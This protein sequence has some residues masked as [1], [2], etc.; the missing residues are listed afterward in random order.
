MK[1]RTDRMRRCET[2]RIRA[3]LIITAALNCFCANLIF[4]TL[5][6]RSLPI[7]RTDGKSMYQRLSRA[8]TFCRW[9]F[10]I[11]D[12]SIKTFHLTFE[13]SL[14]SGRIFAFSHV[15][16]T[17]YTQRV[18]ELNAFR[19]LHFTTDVKFSLRILSFQIR[20]HIKKFFS[21]YYLNAR[22]DQRENRIK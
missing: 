13:P 12:Q 7:G 22:C 2:A 4:C 20:R 17:H 8:G 16:F 3:I 18:A 9:R 21:E 1:D 5:V 19:S 10:C 11:R 6:F 15:I 14:T